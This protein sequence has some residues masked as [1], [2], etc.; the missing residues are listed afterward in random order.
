MKT[1]ASHSEKRSLGRLPLVMLVVG[2]LGAGVTGTLLWI[3]SRPASTSVTVSD[4]TMPGA[5]ANFP[6]GSTPP[7][8]S[9]APTRAP[10]TPATGP[11]TGDPSAMHEPP[12]TLTQGMTPAQTALTL[13][14]WY[15]DHERWPLA[16]ENYQKALAG[17]L[18]NP[19]IR[20]DFGNALRFSGQPQ[21][22][23]EQYRLAQKQNPRHENSLFNQGAVYAIDLKQPAKGVAVWREYLKKFPSGQS[24]TQ[25]RRLIA[26]TQKSQ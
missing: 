21:K 14:N 25:A 13:G 4:S 17:G 22:A 2:A 18:D 24:V 26:R 16:I 5:G 11:A 1:Q 3:Q 19:N 6:S 20:T 23:L 12:T 10:I 8:S 15:Y 7:Q 9:G